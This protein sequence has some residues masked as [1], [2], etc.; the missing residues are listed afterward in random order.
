MNR[1]KN[2]AFEKTFDIAD[3]RSNFND[4]LKDWDRN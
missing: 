1:V 4:N 3:N 2:Y